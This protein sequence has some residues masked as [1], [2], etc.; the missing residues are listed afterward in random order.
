M[1]GLVTVGIREVDIGDLEMAVDRF[2]LV[3]ARGLDLVVGIEDVEE[4][5]GIDKG[6]VHIVEYHLKLADRGYHVGEQ[7][8][9]IHD[10]TD[11]HAGIADEDQIGRQD[12]DEDGAD[13]LHE[14]LEAVE[15]EADLARGHLVVCQTN[16]QV[17][18]LVALDALAV[19]RLDDVD[20]LDDVHDA[21]ALLLVVGAHLSPPAAKLLGL[22]PGDQ[23]V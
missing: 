20:A 10:L 16:L 23:E 11:G 14:A 2:G 3:T 13:L 15:E 9:M 18:L 19:E 17:Q 6:L 4:S 7:H 8:D 5:F 22:E 21:V 12:D 1:Q